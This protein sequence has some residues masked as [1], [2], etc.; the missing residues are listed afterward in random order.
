MD[1][2][3]GCI[4]FQEEAM[5]KLRILFEE[6]EEQWVEKV[7][8]LDTIDKIWLEIIGKELYQS[9]ADL[10]NELLNYY[11]DNRIKM[12]ALNTKEVVPTITTQNT[13]SRIRGLKILFSA[14]IMEI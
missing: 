2:F 8:D 6:R 5:E 10:A 1:S 9:V 3:L 12:V 4:N 14:R 11:G 7:V 13:K